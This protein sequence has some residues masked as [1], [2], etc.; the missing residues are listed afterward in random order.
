MVKGLAFKPGYSDKYDTLE[1]M[2]A[3]ENSLEPK[4]LPGCKNFVKLFRIFEFIISC[5]DAIGALEDSQNASS[6]C[7]IVYT[8]TLA[9]HH[10]WFLQ[11]RVYFSLYYLPTKKEIYSKI[12]STMSS[13]PS[14]DIQSL[15]SEFTQSGH[16]VLAICEEILTENDLLDI[17]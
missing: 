10:S 14:E 6:V 1:K 8:K 12:A 15:L 13:E 4:T 3:Y 2:I 5:I 11:K 7:K 9:K 16:K 17:C